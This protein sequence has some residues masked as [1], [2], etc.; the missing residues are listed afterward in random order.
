[1][2]I[3]RNNIVELVNKC[4]ARPDKDYGQNFLI[5][6]SIA[7]QIVDALD[8]KE[9][10]KVLEVGPGL[11]SLTHFLS[12]KGDLT[13]CDIDSRMI[14]FLK[15]I[16]G[17]DVT[18]ILDDIRKVDVSSFDKI[19][20]NLP[21]NITTELVTFLLV[22]AIS[23]KKMV[24][25]CQSEAFNRF[26]DKSGENY[27]PVSVLLHLLGESKKVLTVKAGS[28]YPVPK[29]NS[30]VFTFEYSPKAD[31]ETIYGVYKLCKSLFLNRRKTINN[32]LKNY[33]GN[34][35]KVE[36]V[37]SSLGIDKNTRPEAISPSQYLMMYGLINK[38]ETDYNKR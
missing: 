25:M 13:V 38:K 24:L 34:N 27:G 19:I 15:P 3:N 16:Y 12:D 36:E 29:C 37:L 35:E 6:P 4:N 21:Y 28:F 18:Y 1:M 20:G 9:N 8:A 31:R 26:Y 10:D 2:E 14:D 11:G 33:L 30:I 5:E 22:N 23:T 17:D 7:S 32:N